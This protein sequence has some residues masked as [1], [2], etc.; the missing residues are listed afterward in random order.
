[1]AGKR[2]D[3]TGRLLK[4]GELHRSDGRYEFRYH[5]FRN[6]RRSIYAPTLDELRDKEQLILRDLSDGIDYA[7][8]L[9]TVLDLVKRYLALKQGTRYNTKIN[10][11]FVLNLLE[12]EDFSYRSINTIKPS[13]GKGFFIKL[14]EDGRKYSTITT[15]R[16][17]LRPAFEM[18]IEDDI[19]RRNPFT[20][21]ITDVVPN[22]TV[23]RKA[24]THDEKEKFLA[25]VLEDKCRRKYYDEIV[26]LL[27]TGMRISE[28]CGLTKSDIDFSKRRIRI[29]RQLT[30]TKEGEY[31]IEKPKT[32]S[33]ERYIPMSDT[34]Y[35]AFQRVIQN[36]KLRRVE[37]VVQGCVGFLFLDKDGK[38]KVAGHL[39]HAMK[40]IVDN[41]NNSH[42]DKLEVTPHILRH[43]FCTDMAASGMN[44][45]DL[46]YV[47]GHADAY[48][49]ANVYTHTSY[50]MAE[51]AMAKITMKDTKTDSAAV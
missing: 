15:V 7:A 16:G 18:A 35:Q 17:V 39:E 47:M 22:D 9:M 20:F 25:Y 31:Y 32:K 27:G 36:R 6:H 40:R 42:T 2:K 21:K 37:P 43:T 50:E 34:V 48:T 10:Y 24:L 4:T 1:M 11:Q 26:I 5:D 45:K 41:Y 30:R 23:P 38:P 14:H 13:D 19:L 33:G 44:L 51:K 46:Q 29:E 49:T 8:G 3:R 28:L 12:K